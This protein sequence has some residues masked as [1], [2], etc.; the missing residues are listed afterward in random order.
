MWIIQIILRLELYRALSAT[1]SLTQGAVVDHLLLELVR[2]EVEEEPEERKR[3][4]QDAEEYLR[5]AESWRQYL[6]VA[7]LL[8]HSLFPGERL[9][10]APIFIRE[11]LYLVISQSEGNLALQSMLLG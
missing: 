2:A 7:F 10:P 8:Q 3:Q 1:L 4:G 9:P 5:A 6:M 11:H